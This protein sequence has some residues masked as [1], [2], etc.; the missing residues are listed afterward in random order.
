MEHVT[1]EA[2]ENPSNEITGG[3][4]LGDEGSVGGQP[5]QILAKAKSEIA[6]ETYQSIFPE[7]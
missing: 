4:I 2:M 3:F 7:T 1:T 5:E 6:Q